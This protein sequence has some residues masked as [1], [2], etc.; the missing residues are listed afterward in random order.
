MKLFITIICIFHATSVL[1]QSKYDNL[2]KAAD[3][4]CSLAND[5]LMALQIYTQAISIS[6]NRWEAYSK[7]AHVRML[8]AASV[9]ALRD[10]DR[11]I[12]L[13]PMMCFLYIQRANIKSFQGQHK[14]ALHEISIAK[15]FCKEECC[16]LDLDIIYLEMVF[17]ENPARAQ[18]MAAME[19]KD[20][21]KRIKSSN[22]TQK[23]GWSAVLQE[24][25]SNP[26]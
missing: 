21:T 6:P 5:N 12:D 26:K 11:A 25:M 23:N 13:A 20:L 22:C 7:R 19:H 1:S 9:D 15:K 17:N 2:I 24:I 3:S 4:C 10:M 8:L 16:S 14:E 18:I